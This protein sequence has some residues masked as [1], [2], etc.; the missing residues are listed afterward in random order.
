MFLIRKRSVLLPQPHPR[1]A[2]IPHRI[3]HQYS[4]RT[5]QLQSRF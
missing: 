3:D 4:G 1:L 5:H 2:L